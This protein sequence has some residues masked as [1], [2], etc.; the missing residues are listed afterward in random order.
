MGSIHGVHGQMAQL[1]ALLGQ[2][3]QLNGLRIVCCVGAC[4]TVSCMRAVGHQC[5]ARE[6]QG[7]QDVEKHVS[8]QIDGMH[9]RS[10][11]A[12]PGA[13]HV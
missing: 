10:T 12:L 4:T 3:A 11:E 5:H 6:R 9:A 13:R 1:Y 8:S 2:M 7:R